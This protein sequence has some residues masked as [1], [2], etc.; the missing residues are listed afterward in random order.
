MCQRAADRDRVHAARSLC[1]LRQ[2]G[3]DDAVGAKHADRHVVAA[4]L[5]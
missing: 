1:L 2:P 5:K 4:D 3:A